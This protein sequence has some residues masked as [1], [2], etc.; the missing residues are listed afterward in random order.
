M[1]NSIFSFEGRIRRTE[2]GI[3]FIVLVIAQLLIGVMFASSNDGSFN[4]AFFILMLPVR[5]FFF[6]QGAKRCHDVNISGW[7]QL[8]PLVPL[9]LLFGNGVTGPNKYGDDPKLQTVNF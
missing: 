9:Y 6:A 2:Y 3:S 1:F 8:I 4:V 7:C 5:F